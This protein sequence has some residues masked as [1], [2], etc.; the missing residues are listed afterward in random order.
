MNHLSNIYT[1][2]YIPAKPEM[3]KKLPPPK[4][5]TFFGFLAILRVDGEI[6]AS[7]LI[8]RNSSFLH[9]VFAPQ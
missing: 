9:R 4:K 7:V 8:S 6:L 5:E 3:L 1:Y 2:N